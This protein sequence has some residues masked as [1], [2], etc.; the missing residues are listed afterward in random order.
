M[1]FSLQEHWSGVPLPSPL[2]NNS[3]AFTDKHILKLYTLTLFSFV[4]FTEGYPKCFE[5]LSLGQWVKLCKLQ[6]T[7]IYLHCVNS[8]H[9]LI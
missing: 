8:V 7:Q 5:L 1:G 6:S 4:S 3:Q 9:F 2:C